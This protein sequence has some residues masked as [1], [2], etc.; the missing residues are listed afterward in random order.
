MNAVSSQVVCKPLVPGYIE[1]H[2]MKK[3]FNNILII[4]DDED[5]LLAARLLLKQQT[6][7]LDTEKDPETIPA[8]LKDKNYDII[9]LDMNFARDATSGRE[10]FYWLEKI[11]KIDPIAVVILITAFG[12]VVMAVQ[13][14]KAGVTD[15]VL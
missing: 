7:H 13:A 8:L 15:F 10:G 6:A 1:K 14:V 11:L 9:L 5:V 12:D 2:F 4:D 3:Q